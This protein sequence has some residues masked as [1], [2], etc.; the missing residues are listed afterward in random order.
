L[1][2]YHHVTKAIKVITFYHQVH[3]IINEEANDRKGFFCE[4]GIAC[5]YFSFCINIDLLICIFF[6]QFLWFGAFCMWFTCT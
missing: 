3:D 1:Y 5:H 6:T 2:T 4:E